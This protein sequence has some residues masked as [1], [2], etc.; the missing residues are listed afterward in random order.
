MEHRK[1]TPA[2]NPVNLALKLPTAKAFESDL[3]ELLSASEAV[4]LAM[5]D[6]DNF[7]RVNTAFG[8]EQ[9]DRVLIETGR[10]LAGGIPGGARLYRYGGDA[11]AILFTGGLEK[12]DVFLLMEKLRAEF[13]VILPDGDKMTI[14]AGIASAPEDATQYGELVRKAEGAM[15][16]GKRTGHNKVCLAREEKMVVKTTHYTSDQL[17]RLAKLSKREGANDAIL[18]REAL[19]A[20][21]KK[22]DV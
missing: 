9:G 13:N 8:H 15:T 4:A 1:E 10:Y 18:L 22:Y 6:M 16:R 3:N 11:F 5:I 2:D 14:T 20:L 19:D 17:H 7:M 12:E 21:L